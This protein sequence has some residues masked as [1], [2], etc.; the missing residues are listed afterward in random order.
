MHYHRHTRT[1]PHDR[2]W[3]QIYLIIA[4]YI[5]KRVEAFPLPNQ[6]AKTVA[7]KLVNEVICHFG[8]PLMIHSDQGQNFKS[9][10]FA[11]VCQLQ[12]T[13]MTPYHPPSH[14][15]VERYNRTLEM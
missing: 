12:K 10:L 11:K 1:S 13:R 14:G 2:S 3:Q 9:A 15:M 8:V 6:E 7:D 4:D 5:T